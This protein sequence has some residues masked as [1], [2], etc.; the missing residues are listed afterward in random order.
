MIQFA[1]RLN[2]RCLH[3]ED[4]HMF[5]KKN[6]NRTFKS[7]FVDPFKQFKFGLYM[8]GISIG[9]IFASG[10]LFWLA[11]SDQYQQL[12]GIFQVV[13]PNDAWELQ[14]NDVFKANAYRIITFFVVFIFVTFYMAF[15]L[16]HKYYGP[17]VSI[18]RFIK[19]LSNGNYSARVRIRKSDELHELVKKLNILADQLE[20]KHPKSDQ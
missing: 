17:L 13:D 11:F 12:I 4:L 16:T 3:K 9:F 2:G 18:E 15:K 1:D 7:I 19:E 6:N 8:V 10:Y 20:Q 5:F 14:L